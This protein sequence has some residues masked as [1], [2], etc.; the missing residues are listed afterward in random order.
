MNVGYA[1]VVLVGAV[2]AIDGIWMLAKA[3]FLLRTP[4]WG[5]PKDRAALR[6]TGGGA[7]IGGIGLAAGSGVL[8]AYGPRSAGPYIFVVGFVGWCLC[9]A[10][11]CWVNRRAGRPVPN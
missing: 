7:A 5:Y 6:L 8:A 3:R 9:Y 4:R 11:A 1:I 10:A 2:I